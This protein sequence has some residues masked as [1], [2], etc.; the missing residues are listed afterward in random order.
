[1]SKNARPPTRISYVDGLSFCYIAQLITPKVP[2]MAVSTVISNF[3]TSF[4]L[5]FIVVWCLMLIF[6]HGNIGYLR[7]KFK[8]TPIP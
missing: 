1:M 8:A 4:Q 6:Y 5:I 2:A 3:N 7:G